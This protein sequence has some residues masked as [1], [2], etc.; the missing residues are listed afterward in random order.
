MVS[1]CATVMIRF[2]FPDHFWPRCVGARVGGDDAVDH[3]A[4]EDLVQHAWYFNA[5]DADRPLVVASFT[6]D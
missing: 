5:D 3:S 4:R 2:G 1:N 6:Q